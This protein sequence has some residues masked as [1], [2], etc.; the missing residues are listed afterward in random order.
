MK[1]EYLLY[2]PDYF[3][4]IIYDR[5]PGL[6]DNNYKDIII[7]NLQFLDTGIV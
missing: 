6:A 7:E 2:P 5:K 3:T 4:A 1:E